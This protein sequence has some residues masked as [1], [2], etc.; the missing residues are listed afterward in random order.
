VVTGG[1]KASDTQTLLRALQAPFAPHLVAHLKSDGNAA[2]LSRLASF[3]QELTSAGG[4]ATAHICSGFNCK[5]STT[6][7]TRMLEQLLL[8]Q[9]Q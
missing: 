9:N 4:A 2:D 1:P 8:R 7:V 3:T 6:D 5:E